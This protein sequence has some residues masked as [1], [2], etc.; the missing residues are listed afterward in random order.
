[1]GR[2]SWRLSWVL[3]P[4]QSS[5]RHGFRP[6]LDASALPCTQPPSIPPDFL[7][8]PTGSDVKPQR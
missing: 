4:R 8:Q 6:D 5:E 3:S 1:M 7:A 2:L